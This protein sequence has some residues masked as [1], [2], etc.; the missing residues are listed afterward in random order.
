MTDCPNPVFGG[1]KDADDWLKNCVF[2]ET[3]RPLPVLASALAMLRSLMP[4]AFGYDEMA[5][6]ELLMQAL[7]DSPGLAPRPIT[8][9]DVGV[10]QE[11]LQRLG[12]K[13]LSKEVMHQA[14]EVRARECSFHPVRNWLRS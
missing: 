4:D 12:L 14:I 6:S 2:G 10:V 9:V 7:D 5:R 13:R 3:G 11:R 8:D 1:R